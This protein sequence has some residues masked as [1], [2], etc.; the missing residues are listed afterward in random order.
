MTSTADDRVKFWIWRPFKIPLKPV[1]KD[2]TEKGGRG[3]SSISWITSQKKSGQ[4]RLESPQGLTTIMGNHQEQYPKSAIFSS[5]ES[6]AIDQT[7]GRKAHQTHGNCKCILAKVCYGKSS[8]FRLSPWHWH[9]SWAK[10]R[11]GCWATHHPGQ[12][13]RLPGACSVPHRS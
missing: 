2:G 13:S 10:A 6:D 4:M 12:W 5:Q 3:L 11:L 9:S 7:N 1:K 8:T